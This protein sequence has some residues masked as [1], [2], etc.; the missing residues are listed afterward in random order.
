MSS[1]FVI[2]IIYFIG[3]LAVIL[4]HPNYHRANA[5]Q[6]SFIRQGAYLWPLLHIVLGVTTLIAPMFHSPVTKRKR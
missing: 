1:L 6:R 2:I 4:G 5:R 3:V